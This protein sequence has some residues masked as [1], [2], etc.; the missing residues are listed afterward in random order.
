MFVKFFLLEFVAGGLAPHVS[1]G[2][3]SRSD[4]SYLVLVN[5]SCSFIRLN[6]LFFLFCQSRMGGVVGREEPS[7]LLF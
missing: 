1:P 6:V 3:K 4:S 2:K 7:H 5:M